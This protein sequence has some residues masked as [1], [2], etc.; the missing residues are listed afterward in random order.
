MNLAAILK[1][2]ADLTCQI[3]QFEGQPI[4]VK[5]R[6]RSVTP[7]RVLGSNPKENVSPIKE[8]EK[9]KDK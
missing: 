6:Q 8:G 9:E 5:K 2:G 4:P 7:I 1:V 3:E